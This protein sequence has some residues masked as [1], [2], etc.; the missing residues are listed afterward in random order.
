MQ[1]GYYIGWGLTAVTQREAVGMADVGAVPDA[2][3][4][5]LRKWYAVSRGAARGWR[6]G[7][8]RGVSGLGCE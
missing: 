2:D 5:V 8:G 3:R 1:A 6:R 4:S 7:C